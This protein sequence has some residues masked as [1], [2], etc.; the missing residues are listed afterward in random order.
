[1][2]GCR[3][4]PAYTT[5]NT[6]ERQWS[7]KKQGNHYSLS[8]DAIRPK[9]NMQPNGMRHNSTLFLLRAAWLALGARVQVCW[10]ALRAVCLGAC[11]QNDG[12]H[13][14]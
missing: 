2:Y 13:R 8:N 7:N 14:A 4:L 11:V 5:M 3:A 6:C 12:D 10:I 9:Q 1:M